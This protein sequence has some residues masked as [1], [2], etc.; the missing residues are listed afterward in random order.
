[1]KQLWLGSEDEYLAH[2]AKSV[3]PNSVLID[4]LNY[5]S[6][7]E[8]PQSGYTSLAD[9][10]NKESQ[11][12][13]CII[14][15]D[16]VNYCPPDN[17]KQNNLYLENDAY[18]LEP[19]I[20]YGSKFTKTIGLENINTSHHTISNTSE[21]I[22]CYPQL[23]I[24]G[25][26]FSEAIGVSETEN[27]GY[28]LSKQLNMP[29]TNLARHGSNISWSADQILRS[30]II[31]GD[32]VVWGITHWERFSYVHK[33]IVDF[34]TP[35]NNLKKSKNFNISINELFSENNLHQQLCTILQVENYCKKID[36]KLR[37]YNMFPG[38]SATTRFLSN[39]SYN[40]GRQFCP[41]FG[42]SP[43][44]HEKFLDLGT[45]NLH[46]GPLT[47]QMYAK[48]IFKTLQI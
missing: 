9:L 14:A 4:S 41:E 38:N 43:G 31:A 5:S 22:N 30:N 37:C 44:L 12:W 33:G 11:I 6:W 46:P 23:W 24:A 13:N 1:M 27:Y 3:D 16:I 28:L 20:V 32:I 21:R 7:L 35:I 42:E 8:S 34:I 45:D 19:L 26:S 39:K 18:V 15:S 2:I 17:W 25:C 48:E 36:A 10:P 47:H 29:V 40:V